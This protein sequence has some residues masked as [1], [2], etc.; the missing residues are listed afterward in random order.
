MKKFSDYKG[1]QGLY[2]ATG[3]KIIPLESA[4]GISSVAQSA[5]LS[6]LGGSVEAT[7][8]QKSVKASVAAASEFDPKPLF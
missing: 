1:P 3:N 5:M 4:E 7:A 8:Y 6:S 2:V